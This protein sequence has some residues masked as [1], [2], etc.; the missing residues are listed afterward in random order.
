MANPTFN[1]AVG[2]TVTL[3]L[4]PTFQ[5]QPAE[6]AAPAS[7]VVDPTTAGTVVPGGDVADPTA[8]FT[9]TAIGPVKVTGSGTGAANAALSVE[10]DG[11]VGLPLADA[12]SG[13][14]V[15]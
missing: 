7:W 4:I 10:F 14:V 1:S 12:L 2:Q 8:V 6:L 3:E 11:T 15:A 13:R 9:S 5:G